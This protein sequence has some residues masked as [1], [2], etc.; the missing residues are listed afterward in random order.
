MSGSLRLITAADTPNPFAPVPGSAVARIVRTWSGPSRY[1]P[2]GVLTVV[3]PS[4][5]TT[6]PSYMPG[7]ASSDRG[8]TYSAALAEPPAR[9]RTRRTDRPTAPAGTGCPACVLRDTDRSMVT[10]RWLVLVQ[11]ST[12]RGD[13]PA[14]SWPRSA[15]SWSAVMGSVTAAAMSS[16]PPPSA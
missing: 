4:R 8:C 7:E 2:I 12:C 13:E 10:A 16:R 3:R 6:S 15:T 1:R 5:A 9:I 14:V 11:R